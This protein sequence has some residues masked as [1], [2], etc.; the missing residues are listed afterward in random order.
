MNN[1]GSFKLTTRG[2][3]EIVLILDRD[4]ARESVGSHDRRFPC[5]LFRASY[6]G[7]GKGPRRRVSQFLSAGMIRGNPE[8]SIEC[9]S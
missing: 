7:P 4:A 2:D 6:D 1:M 8:A 9:A 5:F 3:Q